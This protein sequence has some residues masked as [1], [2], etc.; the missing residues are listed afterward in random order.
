MILHEN[1]Q[2]KAFGVPGL[3]L[4]RGLEDEIVISPYSTLM[5]LPF[6]KNAGIKN[7]KRLEK[8]GAL[9][10]YGFI[11]AIDYTKARE[12]KYII[13]LP[14]KETQNEILEK[15][16][17]DKYDTKTPSNG[18]S[19]DNFLSIEN[20]YP[21]NVD[22]NGDYVD[23]H[24]KIVD[25]YDKN[26][27]NIWNKN[28]GY[29]VDNVDNF[30]DNENI[31]ESN[32]QERNHEPFEKNAEILNNPQKINKIMTYMVHHLGMSLMSLDNILNDNILINRFHNLPEVKATEL[33]LKEKIPQNVTF[34]RNEDFSIKNKYF[35][36]ETLIPRIFENANVDV[37]A[38]FVIK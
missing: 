17:V 22:K 33:L 4:K 1:Y 23:N 27:D 31:Y 28:K 21:Q 16:P 29:N 26:V 25:I 8:I 5:T 3:G 9:G 13:T 14:K 30:E 12:D 35:E 2:Y 11:E 7:L 38:A 15:S 18:K 6:A 19:K 24:D 36:G 10:R 32:L 37:Q 20:N 34:E